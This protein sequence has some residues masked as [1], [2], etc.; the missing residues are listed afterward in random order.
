VLEKSIARPF[1]A[2]MRERATSQA[3]P[4]GCGLAGSCLTK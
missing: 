1:G 4:A 3:T 2:A